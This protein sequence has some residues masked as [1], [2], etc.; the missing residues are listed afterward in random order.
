[1]PNEVAE[2][3][4]EE[5][6]VLSALDIAIEGAQVKETFA[7]GSGLEGF[8]DTG[9]IEAT[10]QYPPEYKVPMVTL[11]DREDGTPSE[12]LTYM[13]S[14]RLMEDKL[15]DGTR[16]WT[17]TESEA[18]EYVLGTV[19]CYFHPDSPHRDEVLEAGLGHVRC[20]YPFRGPKANLRTEYDLEG[21]MA[22]GHPGQWKLLGKVTQQKKDD[23]DRKFREL[24]TKVLM[25]TLERGEPTKAYT[26]EAEDCPR[27]FDSEHALKIHAGRDHKED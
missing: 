4:G 24:N 10:T 11:Y 12:M 18:P 2:Q 22:A 14:D 7:V 6:A 27:F 23:E 26:C 19:K 3:L 1:M 15:P 13:A 16:R 8:T 17:P 5:T 20:G 25:Q 9:T 21:H